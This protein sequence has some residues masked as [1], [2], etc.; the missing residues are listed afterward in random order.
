MLTLLCV[1]SCASTQDVDSIPA[2]QIPAAQAPA[3][4]APAAKNPAPGPLP[5]T[6]RYSYPPP[7]GA[8]RVDVDAYGDW[9]RDLSLRDPSVPVRTYT[10]AIVPHD[11]ARVIELPLV[12]GNLQ[13]CADTAIRLRAE[14]LK[15]TGQDDAILFHATSG[16]AMPWPRYQAGERAYE[17]G[18]HLAW[19]STGTPATWDEYLSAVFMWAGTR[20]LDADTT[21][22]SSPRPGDLLLLPGSPGH[23]VVI[24][25]VATWQDR[26][27]LLVGEGFMPAQDFHLELGPDSGWWP[28]HAGL[29][30]G[31]WDFPQSSL[32]RWK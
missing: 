4:Q 8:S 30:M 22:P 1:L 21:R 6:I 3:A 25:D 28:W 17:T 2:P 27:W 24:L 18:N 7:A 11:D 13:Q 10:G 23:A 29:H 14:W 16:D 12:S 15:Q 31:P 26:T 19:R 9:L 20:S 5:S 32:R